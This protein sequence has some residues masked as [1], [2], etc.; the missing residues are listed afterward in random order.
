MKRNVLL[1]CLAALLLPA[2]AFAGESLTVAASW[3]SGGCYD[4]DGRLQSTN[5]VSA[6]YARAESDWNVRGYARTAPTAPDCTKSGLTFDVNAQRKWDL[7]RT[8][9]FTEFGADQHA[10]TQPYSLEGLGGVWKYAVD[11]SPSYVA[12]IGVGVLSKGFIFEVAGNAVRT[13]WTDGSR[14]GLRARVAYEAAL[15]KTGILVDFRT[16]S[17][18]RNSYLVQLSRRFEESPLALSLSYRAEDGLSKLASPFA[19]M[20]PGGYL[21]GPASDETE[22]L[23]LGLS[24]SF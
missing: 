10:V 5:A 18:R 19:D 11:G 16:E 23:E 20:L 3:E 21:I 12:A 24:W 13:D 7:G 4:G 1:G 14:H 2:L 15:G 6:E 22:V 9:W 17:W 8:Y